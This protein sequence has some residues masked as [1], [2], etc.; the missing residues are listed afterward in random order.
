MKP[1]PTLWLQVL[2]EIDPTNNQ[3]AV[4]LNVNVTQNISIDLRIHG[5]GIT[6][7]TYLFTANFSE[8]NSTVGIAVS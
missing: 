4:V 7:G 6:F 1:S 8:A 2:G 3:R 5:G